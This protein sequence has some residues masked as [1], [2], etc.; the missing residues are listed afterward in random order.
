MKK[1][2]GFTLV[3]LML[4]I[5]IAAILLTMAIPSFQQLTRSNRTSTQANE[6]FTALSMARMSAIE[7]GEPVTVCSSTDQASCSGNTNWKTGWIVFTDINSNQTIDD[8]GDA[9]LCETGQDDDCLLRVWGPLTGSTVL[10]GTSSFISFDLD[11]RASAASS[12]VLKAAATCG[13]GEKRTIAVS[14]TGRVN[15]VTGDCP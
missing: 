9:N 3:E 7:R 10:T 8:D 4:T 1:S 14:A 15:M 6:L 13:S 2:N 5:V 12:I 11:G